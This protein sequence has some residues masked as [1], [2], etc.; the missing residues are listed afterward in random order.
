MLPHALLLLLFSANSQDWKPIFDGKSLAG[1]KVTAFTEHGAV[2]V[3]NGAILMSNGKP[4]TGIN[5]TGAFPKIDYEIQFEAQRVDGN[6]FF[7]SLTL[8][9]NDAFFT[10]VTG[11]WGGDIVGISSIDGWDASDNETRSYFNFDRGKWYKFR[12]SVTKDKMVAWIDDQ[13][14]VD[15]AINGRAISMR[16]GEISLST[17]VGFATYGTIGSIRKVEFRTLPARN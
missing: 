9:Y 17:P 11:G 1:W 10:F 8:P 14:V 5:Y 16:Q 6:D 4:L 15:L 3:E 2:K 12:L 13:T 7:A